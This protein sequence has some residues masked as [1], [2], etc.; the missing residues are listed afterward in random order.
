MRLL[1]CIA[2]LALPSLARAGYEPPP[3][4]DGC[5]TADGRFVVTA[6]PVDKLTIHGPNRWQFVWTDTKEKK[7]VRFDAKGVNGGQI[8][9]HLFVAPDGETFALWNHI[10]LWTPGKSEMHGPKDLPYHED[11]DDWR[12]REEFSR[13]LIIYRKDG[14]IIKELGVGDLVQPEEWETI[15]RMFNRVS[16][17]V[18]YPGLSW[19]QMIRTGYAFYRVSPDYTVLEF[20]VTPSRAAKDKSGRV[21]RVSLIDGKILPDDAKLKGDNLPVRPFRG[22]DY[23]PDNEPKTRES[24]VPSL[25]PVREEGKLTWMAPPPLVDLKLVKGDFKKLDT[26]AWLPSEKCLAF[27]DL[28]AGKLYRL[29]GEKVTE[30]RAGGRGKMGPDGQWYGIIDGKLVAWKSGNEPIAVLK[31]SGVKEL[32]LNDL[33]IS[34]NNLLYFT[35]LKDPEKG[36][37]TVVN[38]KTGTATVC[39]DAEKHP[40]LSNP[41]GIAVSPDGKTLFVA[42]SNYKDRKKAGIYRFALAADGTFDPTEGKKA[43]WAAPAAPDGITFGPDGRLY[44]TDGS[45]VRIYGTDGKETGT[46]KIPQDSGTN[47][48]FG[49]PDGRTLYVTANKA[50]FAGALTP[51]KN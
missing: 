38:L 2:L 50:L 17:I 13:R 32:S 37:V 22:A 30:W 4:I 28:D 8:F 45:L 5:R 29:D 42:V 44:C 16:W 21:V 25:D 40:E 35:T 10:V 14:S 24:Y 41:N 9:G 49:G 1:T 51:P 39:Y 26:P 19:K 7:T 15:G 3:Y 18:P 23:P 6:E 20:R 46:I 34:N 31:E 11:T 33:T 43:K 48:T 27:T 36:R 47:I 12:K